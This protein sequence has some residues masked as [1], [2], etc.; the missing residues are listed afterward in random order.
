MLNFLK[1][2]FSRKDKVI[3]KWGVSHLVAALM[4]GVL[5]AGGLL[6]WQSRRD[7][8]RVAELNQQAQQV[9]DETSP[10]PPNTA[11]LGGP[12]ILTNQDN[13]QVSDRDFPG[14]YLLIYFGYTSCP[15]MCQTGLQSISRAL[16]LLKTDADRVQPLFITVDPARDT[17]AKLKDYDS[18]FSPK[19]IG[20]TGT[21]DQIAAVA[22]EYQVYYQKGEG[23]DQ[24]YEVDHS[25]LIYL[26]DPDGHLV[27]TFDE[28][29]DPTTIVAALQKTWAG[30]ALPP[31]PVA[32]PAV[33]APVQP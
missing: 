25:S 23:D 33:P 26:M 24:E 10:L 29:A 14:K 19:I 16:E 1:H 21:P 3:A 6:I 31:Q 4:V 30:Q 32:E 11:D 17:P 22:R 27:T 2:K 15:D 8:G 9:N 7:E 5:L 18:A 12:F 13:Q 20:L 28:Q